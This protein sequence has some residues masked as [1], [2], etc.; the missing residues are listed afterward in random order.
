MH[1]CTR[2][3]WR[4]HLWAHTGKNGA[5]MSWTRASGW[6]MHLLDACKGVAH[7]SLGRVQGR[8]TRLLA[9]ASWGACILL[10]HACF[11]LCSCTWKMQASGALC[12]ALLCNVDAGVRAQKMQRLGLGDAGI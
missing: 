8:C 10:A 3:C 11:G 9:R 2:A 4:G 12:C 1:L 7:A 5:G 6:C